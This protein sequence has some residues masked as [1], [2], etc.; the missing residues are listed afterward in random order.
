MVPVEEKFAKKREL[1][2]VEP[3]IIIPAPVADVFLKET[4]YPGELEL[5]ARGTKSESRELVKMYFWELKVMTEFPEVKDICPTE[6]A[7]KEDPAV[8]LMA[9]LDKRFKEDEVL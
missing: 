3:E 5:T 7:F 4:A 1:L 6:E 9:L 2:A 8:I